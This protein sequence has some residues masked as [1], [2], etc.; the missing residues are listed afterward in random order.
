MQYRREIDGLRAVAVIP[1]VLFHAGFKVFSGGY[2]GVDVFFVISGYLITAILLGELERGEFS[3]G[4]FYERRAR[5]ILPALF[6]VMLAC[7]PFALL[8]MPPSQIE[9]FGRGLVA[10]TLFAS[11]ILFWRESGYFAPASEERPL[12][13]TWSLAVEEQ[14]YLFFPLLLLLA[15]RLGRPRVFCIVAVI[16]AASLLLCEWGW[17]HA[18]VA[19][20]YLAPTRAWEL[21]AG[22]LCAFLQFGKQQKQND[23][24]AGLGLGLIVLAI[25][26]FDEATPFPSLYTLAPV[27]G[28][29]LIILFAANGTWTARLLSN[30]LLVGVGL[31]SYSL[32][33]WHQP[34]FAFARIYSVH[35]PQILM[36]C[37]A[38]LSLGLSYLSWQYIEKPFRSRQTRF[39]PSTKVLLNGSVAAA[40]M[41][42]AAGQVSS[43]TDGFFE[44]KST[45]R[46]RSLMQTATPSPKRE[47]CHIS[48]ENFRETDA[49]CEYFSK[50]VKFAAFGDS[51]AVELA[52]AL[53]EALRPYNIGLRHLSLSAC[54][55]SFSKEQHDPSNC[56]KWTNAAIRTIIEDTDI[57]TVIISYRLNAYLFGEHIDIYPDLPVE[58]SETE[59]GAVWSSYVEIVRA[60]VEAGK[61]AVVVLQAP[62]LPQKMEEL[63][64]E[65]MPDGTS[66]AGLPR[67]WWVKRTDYVRQ[68]LREMPAGVTII[69]PADLFCDQIVCYAAQG[70]TSY[71]FDDDHLSVAG[72]AIVAARIL[73]TLGFQGYARVRSGRRLA[74][75]GISPAAA[76][77]QWR[78]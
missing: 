11:N 61:K 28:T 68:H 44:L 65:P 6:F 58:N 72:A 38:L 23:L 67:D 69:D 22:S 64:Y 21:L 63:I 40:L 56:S 39:F 45:D 25:F 60:F 78:P 31:I 74:G 48:D 10:V 26:A 36:L 16:A 70:D 30:G 34:L 49:A 52:Y 66:I 3:I 19:T 12:L 35:P 46:Q 76:S 15:W 57:D 20:F 53:A 24:L 7:I 50:N 5:R 55:P 17:R 27:G 4:R 13:H 14:Y 2:I 59:R 42:L 73:S 77:A 47:E 71:Y 18:P 9:D 43:A 32:Y 51:H 41:F 1:V 37:L 62:E 75:P 8:W 54:A 29:A 33:L